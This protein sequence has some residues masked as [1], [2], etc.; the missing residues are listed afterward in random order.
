M[1]RK[2]EKTFHVLTVTN[3][4]AEHESQ[5]GPLKLTFTNRLEALEADWMLHRAGY[6]VRKDMGYK[7]YDGDTQTSILHDVEVFC[8][9]ATPRFPARSVA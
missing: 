8:G 9:K 4:N 6:D 7:L 5:R 2:K 3:P 1:P